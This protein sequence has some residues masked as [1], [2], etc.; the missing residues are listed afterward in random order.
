MWKKKYNTYIL[1]LILLTPLWMWLVWVITPKK[2][3]MLGIIDKTVLTKKGQEHSSL[4]WVLNHEKFAK[5]NTDL[6]ETQR[7]Y[8]GF[9]PLGGEKYKIKGLERFSAAK[10]DELSNDCDVAYLTD[11]YGIYNSEWYERKNVTER[12]GIIYGGMSQQDVDFL[13]KMKARHKLILTE[14]NCLGSPTSATVRADFENTFNMKWTGWIG[15]Y[16]DVLDTAINPELPKWLVQNY[17]DQHGGKWPF[18]KSGIAFVKD[19]ERVVILESQTHLI[20]DLPQIVSKPEAAKKYGVPDKINY[21]FWFDVIAPDTTV[22]DVLA[23]FKIPVNKSGAAELQKAGIP[24]S[25]PAIINH[26]SRDY[27]FWYFCADFSDNPIVTFSS[28][29]KGIPF[30]KR[31]FY[32]TTDPADRRNFFWNVYRPLVTKILN[33][34]REEIK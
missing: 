23:E 11:A 3:L 22:N 27:Q 29:F 12:S 2:A 16:F 6:Y 26:S 18:K 13:K 7:D 5:S 4:M 9:F 30:F 14:F 24:S 19:D 15:R 31:M 1:Y 33:D 21:S 10:L 32:N 17:I 20:R 34:Y 25:F 28:Y 8:F